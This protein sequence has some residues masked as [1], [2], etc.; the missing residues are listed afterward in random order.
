MP[1]IGGLVED[2][3]AVPTEPTITNEAMLACIC[4]AIY[5]ASLEPPDT[6]EQVVVR[7]P[8]AFSR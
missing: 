7:Y 4:D 3:Q 1:D 6:G 2:S 8:F 5:E